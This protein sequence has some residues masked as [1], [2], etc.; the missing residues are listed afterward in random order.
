MIKFIPEKYGLDV[1]TLTLDL[2]QREDLDMYVEKASDLGAKD[3]YL[4]DAKREFADCYVAKAIKAN[5]LYE[6]SY[7]LSSALARPLIARWGIETAKRVGAKAIAHGCSGK[8]NDQIRFDVTIS[9]LAPELRIVAPVREFGLSRDEEVEYAK[10]NDVPI[11]EKSTYSIDENLWGRSIECGILEHPEREPPPDA[12]AWIASVEDAPNQ[13]ENVTI[14]F[15]KGIPVAL[16]GT[17]MELWELIMA[18]NELAGNHGVGL[19]DHVEDRVVGLKSREVYECPAATVLLSAH[20]DLEK[21][22]CTKHENMFKPIVDKKWSE[23]VYDGLWVDPLTEDLEE[24]VDKVNEKVTGTVN[25]KLYKGKATIVGRDSPNALYDLKLATYERA[26][27][28]NQKASIG[29]VK[30]WGLQS[31]VARMVQ[32]EG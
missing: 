23:L 15:D 5:A 24:F 10:K 18:L 14:E 21:L 4:I 17:G 8:G 29:F 9:S 26:E 6:G 16:N 1:V 19:V 13:P 31:K 28:F 20:R 27:A 32:R 12:F 11:P 22:V 7:P 25:V 2:G 30:L 3:A